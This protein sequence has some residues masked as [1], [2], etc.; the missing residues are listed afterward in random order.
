M[1]I[2]IDESGFPHPKD[3]T[4]NPVLAA[5]CLSERGHRS[6]SRNLYSIKRRFFNN[7]E[8]ELKAKELL[9]PYIFEKTN[10]RR[11][12]VEC[13][14][15]LI[16]DTD[17]AIF[18]MIMEHP[19]KLPEIPEGHIPAQYR[20]L[21]ERTHLFVDNKDKDDMAILVFDGDGTTFIP[22][23]LG[24]GISRY[25]FRSRE[26]QTW[27]K[28]LDTPFFVDSTITPGIQLTDMIAGCIRHYQELELFR[29]KSS[30]D[31]FSSAIKRYHRIIE[32]KTQDFESEDKTIFGLYRLP[33][34]Y[35]YQLSREGGD[36]E[37]IDTDPKI[38]KV[39]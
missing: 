35:F 9:R 16:R 13:V 26:G 32:S 8:K 17:L 38:N 2:F 3:D 19:S 28:I 6:L 23:G 11:E 22:G 34:R 1:L 21:L 25:L 27:S 12:L 39:S 20:F 7:P 29:E 14:F 4:L 24:P 36:I 30:N 10:R 37:S 33:E 5:V 18:A 31:T 15:E